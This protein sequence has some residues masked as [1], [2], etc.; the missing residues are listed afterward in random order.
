MSS[1]QIVWV[2]TDPPGSIISVFVAVVHD[3][4]A[5]T[6]SVVCYGAYVCS[7]MVSLLHIK[8]PLIQMNVHFGELS[9][10]R[11]DGFFFWLFFI[12]LRSYVEK[13][14]ILFFSLSP[15]YHHS[16]GGSDDH[17]SCLLWVFM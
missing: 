17:P 3:S 4:V 13:G 1:V 11:K 7:C 14:E 10:F 8:D 6:T 5:M 15:H 9:Y 16:F 12:C 2:A